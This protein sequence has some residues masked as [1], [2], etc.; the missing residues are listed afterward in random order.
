M[1]TTTPVDDTAPIDDGLPTLTFSCQ[2][3]LSFEKHYHQSTTL[4]PSPSSSCFCHKLYWTNVADQEQTVLIFGDEFM[5]SR[6]H[7]QLKCE[8]GCCFEP[9]P[10]ESV[11]LFSSTRGVT[12][13]I[14]RKWVTLTLNARTPASSLASVWRSDYFDAT[15]EHISLLQGRDVSKVVMILP[16]ELQWSVCVVDRCIY[17]VTTLYFSLFVWGCTPLISVVSC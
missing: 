13:S 8:E 2:D 16:D 14:A 5:E 4:D 9:G 6:C 11:I 12:L 3:I 10:E 1:M 15:G 7:Q 17:I